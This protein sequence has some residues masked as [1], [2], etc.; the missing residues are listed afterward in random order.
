MGR[1]R[2]AEKVSTPLD[3]NS[4]ADR[5]N[6]QKVLGTI[7]ACRISRG[8][9]QKTMAASLLVTRTHYTN[10]E[11]GKHAPRILDLQAWCRALGL[12]VTITPEGMRCTYAKKDP[13]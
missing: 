1:K 5:A 3:E 12:R 8:I 13:P 9:L 6:L 10:I 4:Q 11:G 2:K 7:R